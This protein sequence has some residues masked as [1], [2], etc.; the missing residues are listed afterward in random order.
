MTGTILAIYW[1]IVAILSIYFA[2]LTLELPAK[3]VC[4]ATIYE[5]RT[6]CKHRLW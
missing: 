1:G 2:V 6:W 5:T 3:P 4:G